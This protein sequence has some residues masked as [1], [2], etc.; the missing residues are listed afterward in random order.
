[1][2]LLIWLGAFFQAKTLGHIFCPHAGLCIAFWVQMPQ[3]RMR[4]NIFWLLWTISLTRMGLLIWS[5]AYFQTKTLGHTSH[6]LGGL[7]VPSLFTPASKF[8]HPCIKV[9]SPP[10]QSLLTP[11]SEFI[12]PCIKAYSPLHQSLFTPASK[13]I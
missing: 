13:F 8:I 3:N 9:Y 11:A 6:P 2:G 4:K 5:G 1:M 10:H 7:C 12:H